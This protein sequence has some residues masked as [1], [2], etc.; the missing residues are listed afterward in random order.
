MPKRAS[1]A[2]TRGLGQRLTV[3]GAVRE[4][5]GALSSSKDNVVLRIGAPHFH[6]APNDQLAVQSSS[7]STTHVVPRTA[8]IEDS[9]PQGLR[10]SANADLDRVPPQS[11]V[12]WRDVAMG[13]SV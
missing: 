3:I 11:R 9:D 10:T 7:F 13:G 5:V 12:G 1:K 6:E 4:H 8:A 2:S